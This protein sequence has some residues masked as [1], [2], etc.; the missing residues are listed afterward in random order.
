MH[1]ATCPSCGALW[2]W[3]ERGLWLI[4]ERPTFTYETGIIPPEQLKAVI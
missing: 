4:P 3:N 1:R 2:E